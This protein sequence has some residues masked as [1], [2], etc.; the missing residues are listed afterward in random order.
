MLMK[1]AAVSPRHP[2]QDSVNPGLAAMLEEVRIDP[3]SFTGSAGDVREAIQ[4]AK[5]AM[6]DR[7]GPTAADYALNQMTDDW[8]YYVFPNVTFNIHPEGVLVQRF[9]PHPKDPEKAIYDVTVLIHPI[10]DPSV[11]IP[12]YMGLDEGAD[13]TGQVRPSRRY[14]THG[15]GGVG[16]VLE[17]DGVMVPYVQAGLHSRAFEGVRL[18][19]QEQRV[20]HYHAEIDRYLRGEKW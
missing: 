19:E 14:L 15:D 12:A 11:R 1:F 6:P 9:R 2:D 4:K 18:S 20:R 7:L 8:A 16:P 13:L 17:Q 3:A 5:H 10:T